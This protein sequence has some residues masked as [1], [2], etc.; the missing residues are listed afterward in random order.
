MGSDPNRLTLYT[1]F[2]KQGGNHYY[3][4]HDSAL[5]ELISCQGAVAVPRSPSRAG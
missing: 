5:S 3:A 1:T 4:L 2:V